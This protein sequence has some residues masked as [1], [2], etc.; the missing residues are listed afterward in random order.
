VIIALIAVLNGW[1][2]WHGMPSV[3]WEP[4]TNADE[5]ELFS[6]QPDLRP[7]DLSHFKVLGKVAISDP[8]LRA[9]LNAALQRGVRQSDG[10]RAKC[11]NP[12]HGIR[13]TRNGVAT[14]FV[15]CFECKQVEV[16]RGGQRLA[17]FTVTNS[18]Q[19][20]FDEVLTAAGVPLAPKEL[21]DGSDS[22]PAGANP[23]AT[24]SA[25]TANGS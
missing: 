3:A 6:I 20:T 1:R 4:L 7:G 10:L 9:K 8:Q 24:R 23:A 18:P 2:P 13:V 16:W 21:P 15:I 19:A 5:Y 14:D 12:R 22:G 17:D 11:F 25:A